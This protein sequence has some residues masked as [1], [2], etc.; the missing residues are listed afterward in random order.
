[1]LSMDCMACNMSVAEVLQYKFSRASVRDHLNERRFG[2]EGKE[3][4]L[5]SDA[6]E[7]GGRIPDR[8]KEI[9][10]GFVSSDVMNA[11]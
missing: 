5:P 10:I 9:S 11:R 4:T 2:P 3:H 7:Y 1:M 6:A 8:G